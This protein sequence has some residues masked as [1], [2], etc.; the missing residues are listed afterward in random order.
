MA[1]HP[2]GALGL[3]LRGPLPVCRAERTTR[4]PGAEGPRGPPSGMGEGHGARTGPCIARPP[5]GRVG[6]LA[7]RCGGPAGG[8]PTRSGGDP[9]RP[10]VANAPKSFRAC[11]ARGEEE[12]E[13]GR[14]GKERGEREGKEEGGKEGREGERKEEPR[15]HVTVGS[16][17]DLANALD[18][19]PRAGAGR[20]C[21]LGA[22]VAVEAI[23]LPTRELERHFTSPQPLAAM[24]WLLSTTAR[25]SRRCGDRGDLSRAIL[26]AR[27]RPRQIWRGAPLA[28]CFS[29]GA[30]IMGSMCS[31]E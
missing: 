17:A 12:G 10:P 30:P 29:G 9:T 24:G 16:L 22:F 14:E 1:A 4:E 28:I 27:V 31:G 5:P 7:V 8:G 2:L 18:R 11:G 15:R 20:A 3:T 23:G 6:T 25:S 19:C 13:E 21:L 26:V